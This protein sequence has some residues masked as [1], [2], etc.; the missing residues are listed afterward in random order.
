MMATIEREQV[1][2]CNTCLDDWSPEHRAHGEPVNETAMIERW[3][4]AI[5]I[6]E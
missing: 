3:R 5:D 4:E 6:D 2:V 1:L